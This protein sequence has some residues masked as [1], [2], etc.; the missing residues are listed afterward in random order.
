MLYEFNLTEVNS[1]R[2]FYSYNDYEVM[3]SNVIVC[4][5][6]PYDIP[7]NLYNKAC[8]LVSY[9]SESYII[10]EL[11]YIDDNIDD[12]YN[13]SRKEYFEYYTKMKDYLTCY[14]QRYKNDG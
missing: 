5:I 10:G 6:R 1:D 9:P 11:R 4:S 2:V 3:Y 7:T 14:I 8:V 12:Y 13:V